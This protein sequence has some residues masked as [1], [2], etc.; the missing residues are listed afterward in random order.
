MGLIT[1]RKPDSILV[2][3]DYKVMNIHLDSV[4]IDFVPK[5][6]DRVYVCCNV[7]SDEHF[8][9]KTGEILQEVSVHPARIMKQEKCTVKRV[10][11]DWGVLNDDAYYTFDILPA[12]TKLNVGD[13]VCADLIECERVR[14]RCSIVKIVLGILPLFFRVNIFGVALNSPL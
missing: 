2:D 11:P 5:E 10:L 13:T 14:F 6:G 3:T 1:E 9:D 4:E 12:A 8:V 7:Q